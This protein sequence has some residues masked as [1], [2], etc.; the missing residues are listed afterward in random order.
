M[1]SID[2]VFYSSINGEE[3][4]QM[5]WKCHKSRTGREQKV[6]P[7]EEDDFPSA[8]NLTVISKWLKNFSHP[9]EFSG[10]VNFANFPLFHSLCSIFPAIEEEEIEV[11]EL[12]RK[13]RA[14]VFISCPSATNN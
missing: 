13:T 8:N 10:G 9:H 7:Q 6:T 1:A 5:K 4:F 11:E 12:E 14:S 2:S 3:F